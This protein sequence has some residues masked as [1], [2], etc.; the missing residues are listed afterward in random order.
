MSRT[1]NEVRKI[2]I[3]L[4][5]QGIKSEKIGET[6]GITGRTVR[7]WIT[8]VKDQGQNRL[9]KIFK[10]KTMTTFLDLDKLKQ[11]FET[12]KTAFNREIAV[13]FNCSTKTI[14]QWRKRFGYTKKKGRTTYR[15]SNPALKKTT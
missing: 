6:L 2:F 11:E 15:E 8:L 12:N 3:N 1:S 5:N 9:M 7:N 4:Y 10:P 13:K 14:E